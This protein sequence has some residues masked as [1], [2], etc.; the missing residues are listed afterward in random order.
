MADPNLDVLAAWIIA[1]GK[2]ADEERKTS[3]KR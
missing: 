2:A 1:N 3:S